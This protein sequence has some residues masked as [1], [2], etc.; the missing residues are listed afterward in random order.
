M[1]I[2]RKI[3]CL[4]LTAAMLSISGTSLVAFAQPASEGAAAPAAASATL[5]K[6]EARAQ[7]KAARK[8]AHA[9]KNEELKQLESSGYRPGQYDP[10]YPVNVPKAQQK[11]AG[12]AASQ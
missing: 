7:R 6:K 5:T 3:R 12:A 10:N 2:G 11:A 8:A 9:K 1:E 4:V